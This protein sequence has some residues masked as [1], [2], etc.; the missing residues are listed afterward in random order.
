MSNNTYDLNAG[1][2]C[3]KYMLLIINIMFMITAIL[4]MLVGTTIQ[5]IF[6]DFSRFIDNYFYST[7]ALLIAVGCIMLLV[8]TFG[9]VGAMKES[10]MLI[11]IYGLFLFLIFILEIAAAIAAFCLQG[12]V[13]DMLIRTMR[14]SIE[15]YNT[16]QLIANDV[17]FMQRGLEC[18]GIYGPRDWDGKLENHTD[19]IP[20]SCCKEFKPNSLGICDEAFRYGCLSKMDFLISQS[21]MLIATGATTVA[22]VQFLGVLCA[23]MLART[24]RRNKSIRE[25]R[26]W[27]LQQSLGIVVPNATKPI[28][29]VH[30]ETG[31]TQLEKTDDKLTH[32]DP[33]T[34]TANSPSVN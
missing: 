26:R 2:R 10:T 12:D 22:F 24:I 19:V 9:C 14:H 4:L 11:N 18:C 20:Q 8:S 21:A 17:D 3:V 33:V 15:E 13:R 32:N 1:M 23:F 7:P 6:T 25:A 5:A 28:N 27:Q 34:Y 29:S 31:Y 30:Q 16:N